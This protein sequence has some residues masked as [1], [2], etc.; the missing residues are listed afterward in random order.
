VNVP[1]SRMRTFIFLPILFVNIISFSQK[2]PKLVEA[3]L[4]KQFEKIYYWDEHR[5]MNDTTDTYDSMQTANNYIVDQI[6]KQGTANPAFF[7]YHFTALSQYLDVVSTKDKSLRIYSWDTY[8]GGT[9]HIFFAVAL[10][11]GGDKKIHTQSLSDSSEGDPGLWY[12]DVYTFIN[13]GKKFYFCVGDGKYSN[14]D[15]GLQVNVYTVDGNRLTPAHIIKTHK[16]LT[17]SIHVGYDLSSFDG[18]SD[19]SIVFDESTKQLKIPLVD[20]NG[21]MSRK[22]IIYKFTGQHFERTGAK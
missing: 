21:K 8:T 19:H 2:G 20:A 16:G 14:F 11:L 6:I 1:N 18:K 3:D 12:S 17:S 4:K 5:E 15:L 13:Q 22:N 10:Y 9:M 7:N